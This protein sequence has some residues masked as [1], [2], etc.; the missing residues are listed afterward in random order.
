[1]SNPFIG[2]LQWRNKIV[3]RVP[4]IENHDPV[5]L[6][7]K[8]FKESSWWELVTKK[9][10]DVLVF[11]LLLSKLFYSNDQLSNLEV[12]ALFIA[13]ENVLK[14]MAQHSELC[15]KFWLLFRVTSP[16]FKDLERCVRTKEVISEMK[17]VLDTYMSHGRAMLSSSLYY[18]L[19]QKASTIFTTHYHRRQPKKFP[20]K[21][22]IGVGY[23]D[24]GSRKNF[25]LDGTPSW[26]EVASD[27]KYQQEHLDYVSLSIKLQNLKEQLEIHRLQYFEIRWNG[28]K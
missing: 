22:H 27:Y 23:N 18:G 3:S 4:C 8:A 19:K 15:K 28:L 16:I 20:P 26:E 9:Q 1:M 25:A 24:H 5:D 6:R 11:K 12:C 7:E 21:R 13:R 2:G 17:E 14:K 10:D